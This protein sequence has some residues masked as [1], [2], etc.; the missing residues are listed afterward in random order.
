MSGS[1]HLAA[2][3]GELGEGCMQRRVRWPGEWRAYLWEEIKVPCL[4]LQIKA[5]RGDSH[6][7]S[8]P[9]SGEKC[10]FKESIALAQ[11]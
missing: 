6:L 9:V 5:E 10:R 3:R 11:K 2:R 4:A 8:I 1:G 7:L